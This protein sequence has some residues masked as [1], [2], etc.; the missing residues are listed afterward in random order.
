MIKRFCDMCNEPL[1][2]KEGQ[3]Q[4]RWQLEAQMYI[5]S[6]L[7]GSNFYIWDVCEDCMNKILKKVNK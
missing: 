4:T 6:S 3:Y 1:K 2:D 5:G 7:S